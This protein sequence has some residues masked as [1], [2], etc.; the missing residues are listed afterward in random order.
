MRALRM[1]VSKFGMGFFWVIGVL[2]VGRDG[3]IADVAGECKDRN[4]EE[5]HEQI[6]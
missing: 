2:G 5:N 6:R 1:R 3:R 4:G